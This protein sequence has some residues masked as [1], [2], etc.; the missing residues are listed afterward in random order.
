MLDRKRAPRVGRVDGNACRTSSTDREG[1]ATQAWYSA[2][3]SG[4]ARWRSRAASGASPAKA[5][6]ASSVSRCAGASTSACSARARCSEM[7][8]AAGTLIA[9][10]YTKTAHVWHSQAAREQLR[11]E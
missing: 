9:M 1:A 11:A 5:A 7:G 2:L 6:S 10:A 4:D 8:P 3:P